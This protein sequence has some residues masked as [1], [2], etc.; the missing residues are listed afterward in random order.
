MLKSVLCSF[1]IPSLNPFFFLIQCY[2]LKS[3]CFALSLKL[4]HLPAYSLYPFISI[5]L[6]PDNNLLTFYFSLVTQ[7]VKNMP[8]MKD[9]QV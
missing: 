2:Q 1:T 9:T 8:A 5:S 6:F 7:S 3:L 4:I